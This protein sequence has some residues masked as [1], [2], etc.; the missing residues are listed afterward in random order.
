MGFYSEGN[1]MNR[2]VAITEAIKNAL[3]TAEFSKD[4]EAT[5]EYVVISE[6]QALNQLRVTVVHKGVAGEP[7]FRSGDVETHTLAIGVMQKPESRANTD[8]DALAQLVEEIYQWSRR[9]ELSL[10]DGAGNAVWVESS[11]EHLEEYLQQLNQ[12]AAVVTVKFAVVA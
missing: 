5:R 11:S 1:A 10:P 4:F 12:F 7:R 8:L 6:L 9:M 2:T 3:N